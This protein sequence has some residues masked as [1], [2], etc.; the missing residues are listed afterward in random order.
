MRFKKKKKGRDHARIQLPM[1]GLM[2]KEKM[3]LRVKLNQI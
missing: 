3:Y 2:L 1:H